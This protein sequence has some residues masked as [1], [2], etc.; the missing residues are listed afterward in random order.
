V[1][2][3]PSPSSLVQADLPEA[4]EFA[5]RER[6][7]GQSTA[8]L[9]AQ[10]KERTDLLTTG[11]NAIFDRK[12][13]RRN[14]AVALFAVE[15]TSAEQRA[16]ALEKIDEE[17]SQ[18]QFSLQARRHF[19]VFFSF[20]PSVKTMTVC[21]FSPQ[22]A[23]ASQLEVPHAQAQLALRKKQHG[24]VWALIKRVAPDGVGGGGGGDYGSSGGRRHERRERRIHGGRR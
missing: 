23:A 13:E 20:V 6:H 2:N 15:G 22:T 10:Y 12:A 3:A 18:E 16:A 9:T 8:L 7:G 1:K 24:D 21:C 11:L 19:F 14:A 5:L 17:F 4:A